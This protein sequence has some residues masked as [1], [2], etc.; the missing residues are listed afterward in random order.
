MRISD[1]RRMIRSRLRNYLSFW[2]AAT[3]LATVLASTG[4]I[5]INFKQYMFRNEQAKM[6]I[7][8]GV[9]AL[10]LDAEAHAKIV[11]S[12]DEKSEAY[13]KLKKSLQAIRDVS[14]SRYVY[15]MRK[16]EDGRVTFVIDAE[17]NPE[18]V[19]HVG[20]EYT[21]I[22]DTL[23]K[24]INVKMVPFANEKFYTD[25]WGTFLSGYAP[26]FRSDGGLEGYVGLD[27]SLGAYNKA[28]GSFLGMV[29]IADIVLLILLLPIGFI[30]GDRL[31][32]PLVAATD[33]VKKVSEGDMSRDMPADLLGRTDEIGGLIG[34]IDAM[35][36]N[37]TDTINKVKGSAG[38]VNETSKAITGISDRISS[39][40]GQQAES[41]AGLQS[42]AK[43]N[44]SGAIDASTVASEVG[45]NAERAGANMDEA[46]SA[47]RTI[48][49]SS[50]DITKS[51][52]I[53]ADIA[54]QTDVLAVNAAIEAARAG[55][56][57][58]AFAVVASEV[59]KL[60]DRSATA[61]KEIENILE[62][63]LKK[64]KHGVGLSERA[65]AR[66]KTVVQDIKR[67]IEQ[68]RSVEMAARSQTSAI[69]HNA[70]I[71]ETNAECA[72]QLA[73]QAEEMLREA[74]NLYSTVKQ[75]KT[76]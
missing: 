52:S 73:A 55:E 25:K 45:K 8:A 2:L 24:N 38:R 61:A 54:D 16:N 67:I 76:L 64:V 65:G 21:T 13:R 72:K 34:G 32:K 5:Y 12:E 74:E 62:Q 7:L 14:G 1:I 40:S 17:E 27:M 70:S 20:D 10:R 11:K 9:T 43:L 46:L 37:M 60:S 50:E 33:I 41:F 18:N 49:T 39:G 56:H 69:D 68:F 51:I 19:S 63:S 47:I 44:E 35:K 42:A 6:R 29:A 30:L 66:I 36:R 57:G 15:T 58:R 31:S 48:E 3:L 53:I 4:L 22:S 75:F 59:R 71:A 23:K 28:C 26:F